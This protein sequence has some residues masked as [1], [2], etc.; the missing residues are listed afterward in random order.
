[1]RFIKLLI[2]S[3]R[4]RSSFD[5]QENKYFSPSLSS[6]NYEDSDQGHIPLENSICNNDYFS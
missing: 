2:P 6:D 4:H 1:M 3:R 5:I